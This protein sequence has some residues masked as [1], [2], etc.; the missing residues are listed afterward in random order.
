M[1]TF[2]PHQVMI[3]KITAGG[4]VTDGDSGKWVTQGGEV[5]NIRN[6]TTKCD[7]Y[8]QNTLFLGR[9]G[10]PHLGH[11]WM[12]KN[13]NLSRTSPPIACCGLAVVVQ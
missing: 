5:E 1:S 11:T 9:E 2:P 7:F 8:L 12:P 13:P 6:C 10:P 4:G 3:T